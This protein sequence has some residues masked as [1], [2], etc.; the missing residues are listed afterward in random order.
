MTLIGNVVNLARR[1]VNALG[2]DLDTGFQR[3]EYDD[4]FPGRGASA[5]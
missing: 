2:L 3:V 4:V 5:A 1:V